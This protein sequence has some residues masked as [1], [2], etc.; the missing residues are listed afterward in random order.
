MACQNIGSHPIQASNLGNVNFGLFQRVPA[1]VLFI[2]SRVAN[3]QD[4]QACEGALHVHII[5]Y[6]SVCVSLA[7]H[8][9]VMQHHTLQRAPQL[10][11]EPETRSGRRAFLRAVVHA[12]HAAGCFTE[13][14]WNLKD[15]KLEA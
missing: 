3:L 4:V 11:T 15:G 10:C 5:S 9:P 7:P 6:D 8:W 2:S 12:G 13:T 1:V 14:S